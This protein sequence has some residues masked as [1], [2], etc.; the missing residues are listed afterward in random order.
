MKIAKVEFIPIQVK[1]TSTLRISKGPTRIAY[2][3]IIKLKIGG[4][5]IILPDF[6]D[7]PLIW[8]LVPIRQS[9]AKR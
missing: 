8:L 5:D 4:K 2:C 6:A 9:Q 3:V 7:I 1:G